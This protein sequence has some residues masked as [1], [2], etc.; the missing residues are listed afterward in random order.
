MA[1][2]KS[3]SGSSTLKFDDVASVILSEEMRWKSS[4]ETLGK[5]LSAE[6]RGRKM[7]R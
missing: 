2:S 1:I 6:T 4:D 3:V 7:E 5:A